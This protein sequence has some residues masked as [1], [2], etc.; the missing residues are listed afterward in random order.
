MTVLGT[1]RQNSTESCGQVSLMVAD[2]RVHMSS[3][4][5]GRWSL[6]CLAEQSWCTDS[7]KT[8]CET[9]LCG[10]SPGN[11][12][13]L[14]SLQQVK[15]TLPRSLQQENTTGWL[16]RDVTSH[17]Q[18]LFLML[19]FLTHWSAVA[20]LGKTHFFSPST[21]VVAWP[22][23]STGMNVKCLMLVLIRALQMLLGLLPLRSLEMRVLPPLWIWYK[24][25]RHIW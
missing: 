12:Q 8:F 24:H 14:L 25:K 2:L 7:L 4:T 22:S 1:D 9:E 18:M 3:P 6:F 23:W 10:T 11:S 17:Q 20:N 5:V 16:S 19:V 15:D 13:P 21:L